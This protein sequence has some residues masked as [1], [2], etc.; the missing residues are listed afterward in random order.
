MR[1]IYFVIINLLSHKLW[2]KRTNDTN[3]Q[4]EDDLEVEM[5]DVT[6]HGM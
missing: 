6:G 4:N 5:I 2:N 1:C 3:S